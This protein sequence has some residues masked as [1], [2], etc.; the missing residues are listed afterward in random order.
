[1]SASN[2][3][4]QDSIAVYAKVIRWGPDG[5]GFEFAPLSSKD[6]KKTVPQQG[7]LA[8]QETLNMFLKRALV[9][10]ENER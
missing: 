3:R 6:T 8:D 9:H 5:V 10:E 2:E 1:T 4:L 7:D